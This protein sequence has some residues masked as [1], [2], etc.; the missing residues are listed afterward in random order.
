M[1]LAIGI[2]LAY[3]ADARA[4]EH[5]ARTW[6]PELSVELTTE[7]Q[8]S[9]TGKYN[10]ANLLK[11][12]AAQPICRGLKF[13]V[14]TLSANMTA[15]DCIGGELQAFS[16]LDAGNVPLALALGNLSW[17]INDHHTLFVGVRNMN[18]DYFTSD[19]TSLFTNSSCGIFPTIGDN[20]S[21]ANYPEAAMGAH[22]KYERALGNRGEDNLV[23]QA[24][25]YN[26][27]AS[28]RFGGRNNVFRFC[29]KDDGLTLLTQAEWQH[30]GS[31]YFIG[32][33]GHY[34]DAADDSRRKFATTLWAYGEQR[35]S[36]HASL[37]ASYS[38]AFASG[39]RCRDFVG[40]GG[41]Y[42]WRRCELGLFTDYARYDGEAESATELTCKIALTPHLYLQPAA[43]MAFSPSVSDEGGTTS[44]NVFKGIGILRLGACF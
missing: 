44:H 30:R 33:C 7:L 2:A 15:D 17:Q 40:V 3:S 5:N 32:A 6:K 31:N 10:Y 18:E 13:E 36:D 39:A 35:L 16:N 28:S 14:S 9:H 20:Y 21:V 34:S 27:T 22:Y 26:G 11:L 38:H 8:A 41:R 19:V 1:L 37:I 43:H 25:A 23:F 42:A 29:P 24:S 4:Q 12:G